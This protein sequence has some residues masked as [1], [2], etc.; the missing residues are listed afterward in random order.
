MPRNSLS[1]RQFLATSTAA[2]I[3]ASS[4]AAPA[5][6]RAQ[7]T[8]SRIN[9]AFIGVGGRGGAN[10]KEMTKTA[11]ENVVADRTAL[12]DSP[13]VRVTGSHLPQDFCDR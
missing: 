11:E 13:P 1:R 12:M 8:N 2:A 4:L 5:I 9:L 10:L 6:G 7:N 3:S